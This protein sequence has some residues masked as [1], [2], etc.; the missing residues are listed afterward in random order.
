MQLIAFAV[1]R[2]DIIEF[3]SIGE[4]KRSL[5]SWM[6]STNLISLNSLWVL[7]IG[8][9]LHHEFGRPG[10]FEFP[11]LQQ[12]QVYLRT[13][14]SKSGHYGYL[15][16]LN[17]LKFLLFNRNDSGSDFAPVVHLRAKTKK[18]THNI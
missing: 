1:L 12:K 5:F 7:K 16:P 4:I 6:I 8:R 11:T 18:A 13:L 15:R 9:K 10:P 2:L 3:N 17:P 14:N